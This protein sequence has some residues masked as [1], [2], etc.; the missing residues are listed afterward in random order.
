MNCNCCF[1]D[2]ISN[3]ASEIIINA[4]LTPGTEY[5][6]EIKDKFD[7]LYN[8][9]VTTG[10]D[11]ELTIDITQLPD[12]LFTQYSGD[13]TITVFDGCDTVTLTLNETE[14]TCIDFSVKKSNTEKN[15]IP[16]A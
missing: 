2:Y 14:Y 16:C 4:G 5:T 13:F 11:G 7:N 6:V 9:N 8:Q 15:Q 3:C 10:V 12:G 1:N